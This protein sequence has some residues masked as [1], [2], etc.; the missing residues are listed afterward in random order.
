LWTRY[1]NTTNLATLNT[2]AW[3][4][5]LGPGV[6]LDLPQLV[7]TFETA[8]ANSKSSAILNTLGAV[9]LR[10][11]QYEKAITTL[12]ESIRIQASGGVPQDWLL[13]ALARDAVGQHNA[14][15]RR[16]EQAQ[17]WLNDQNHKRDTRQQLD[18]FDTW[19]NRQEIEFLLREAE[20]AISKL[21]R[22]DANGELI[23]AKRPD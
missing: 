21:N 15:I 4:A 6:L 22:R 23:G 5:A 17:A 20:A 9:Y 11:N 10:T 8:A 1:E 3:A 18:P 2:V 14:A 19:T 16:W 13:L 7:E 12:E